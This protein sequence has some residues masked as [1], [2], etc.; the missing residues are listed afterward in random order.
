MKTDS[1]AVVYKGKDYIMLSQSAIGFCEIVQE[2]NPEI[3]LVHFS[4]LKLKKQT[5]EKLSN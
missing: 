3:K 2:G 1:I 4:E 5:K